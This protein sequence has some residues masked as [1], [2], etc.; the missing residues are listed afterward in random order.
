L[1]RGDEVVAT[2]RA[3]GAE[4]PT[5]T[6]YRK[7]F[8]LDT[9]GLASL[10]PVQVTTKL[11][12]RPELRGSL[13]VARLLIHSGAE[14]CR[15]GMQLDVMDCNGPLIPMFER[16][17]FHSYCGWVFHKEFGTVRAMM[18][19]ADTGGYLAAI[20]GPLARALGTRVGDNAFGGYGLLRR[21]AEPPATPALHTAFAQHV[22]PV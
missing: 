5:A 10:A 22:R 12:L 4:D 14:S 9:L 11:M 13:A 21:V 15:L 8:R 19:P 20:G 1:L 18:C 17:G 7:L 3:N 2:I 16:F 6:Y